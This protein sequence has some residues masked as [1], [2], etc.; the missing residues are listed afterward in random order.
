MED[1][2]AVK[3]FQFIPCPD[4]AGQAC[5]YFGVKDDNGGESVA[6][7]A[8]QGHY[9]ILEDDATIDNAAAWLHA[10]HR[11]GVIKEKEGNFTASMI[12]KVTQSLPGYTG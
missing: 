7:V 9:T 10:I 8:H 4:C 1:Q 11:L 2:K 3:A 6:V 5:V 12:N